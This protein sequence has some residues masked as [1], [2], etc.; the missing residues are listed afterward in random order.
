MQPTL[1]R[2][3]RHPAGAALRLA[4]A[5]MVALWAFSAVPSPAPGEPS[6]TGTEHEQMVLAV[7]R[8]TI[9]VAELAKS[10]PSKGK[11]WSSDSAAP[12]GEEPSLCVFAQGVAAHDT[13]PRL[14]GEARSA[15]LPRAP[16][17]GIAA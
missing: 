13:G 5:V 8:P 15:N 3:A 7:K 6:L 16:P 9:A 11:L 2:L 17:R 1:Q 4:C 14:A 10:R 12:F